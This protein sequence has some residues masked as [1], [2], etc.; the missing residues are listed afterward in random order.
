MTPLG[1]VRVHSID[2]VP[3]AELIGEVDI[4]NAAEIGRALAA[5]VT[6]EAVGL[7]VDLSTTTY[8][9]SQ[10]VHLLLNLAIQLRSRQQ[11]LR[12]AIPERSL[13]QRI[14]TLSRADHTIPSH[15]TVAEAVARI[16]EGG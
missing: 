13:V 11:T 6:N 2:G 5:A 8:L 4:S 15:S 10:G 7:V 14:L 3:V 12:V 9:D 1:T 16:R